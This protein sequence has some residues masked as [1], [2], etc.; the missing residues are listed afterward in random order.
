MPSNSNVSRATVAT[1]ASS[2][3]DSP[4]SFTLAPAVAI[5]QCEPGATISR[6]FTI[7]NPSPREL[8]FEAAAQDVVLRD[9]KAV[10]ARAGTL[11][12]GIAATAVFGERFFNVKPRGS[13]S[14]SVSLTV[15][16]RTTSNGV[17]I[18]FRGTDKVPISDVS[19]LSPTLGSLV[20]IS[21]SNGS[22]ADPASG[23]PVVTTALSTIAVSQWA[24]NSGFE[25]NPASGEAT[26]AASAGTDKGGSHP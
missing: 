1:V 7:Y 6:A 10:F 19:G 21:F 18:Q 12:N 5:I 4:D 15:H 24:I 8:T 2:P 14:I 16:P 3:L 26:S 23:S 17:L 9:G 13:R 11:M 20:L 22:T 25:S